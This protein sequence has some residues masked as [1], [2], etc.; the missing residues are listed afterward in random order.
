MQE[1]TAHT[2]QG[3]GTAAGR[4]RA[5][6][7]LSPAA[8]VLA[9]GT[10]AF[11]VALG[12]AGPRLRGRTA[13]T[14]Q[15]CAVGELAEMAARYE[16]RVEL[17][18]ARAA[19]GEGGLPRIRELTAATVGPRDPVDLSS[20]GWLADDA[21]NVE[22]QPG[23]MATMVR[24][25]S[26]PAGSSVTVTMLPDD[27]R[28]VRYDGFGRAVP[29]APGQEWLGSVRAGTGAPERVAYAFADGDT[30]WIVLARSRT[31]LVPAARLLR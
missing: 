1:P 10:V 22:L 4:P 29:L 18:L 23:L 25:E 19:G 17:D 12:I 15:D 16:E 8:T 31:E 24:Y 27:G 11:A 7:R 28:A 6:A 14:Q 9:L 20:A 13:S 21:H 5:G 30:L 26:D 2:A 3:A